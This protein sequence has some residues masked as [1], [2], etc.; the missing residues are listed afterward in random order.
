MKT[1]ETSSNETDSAR[2]K[3]LFLSAVAFDSTAERRAYLEEACEGDAAL[4]DRVNR[5]L[6][7]HEMDDALLDSVPRRLGEPDDA[8]FEGGEGLRGP[9]SGG[10]IG[11]YRLRRE[12]GEGGFGVVWEAEQVEP[13]RRRVALKLLRRDWIGFAAGS[14]AANESLARFRAEQQALARLRHEGIAQVYDAGV[15]SDGPHAGQPYY[16]MELVVGGLPLPEYCDRRRLDLRDRID[17]LTRAADAV[18]HAHTRGVLHRD[19]KPANVLVPSGDEHPA[20]GA[21]NA[22]WPKVIDFGIAKICDKTVESE[23]ATLLQTQPGMAL[24]TPLYAAPEQLAGGEA[25]TRSD[26]FSLGAMLYEL[27]AGM[28]ARGGSQHQAAPASELAPMSRRY[29]AMTEAD[30]ADLASRRCIARELLRRELR[31][32]LDW[33]VTKATAYEPE[34][35]YQ[36]AASLAADLRHWLDGE[37]VHA[38]PPGLMYQA[39]KVIGRHRRAFAAAA[40]AILSIGIGLAAGAVGLV[41]EAHAAKE[42]QRQADIARSVT[43][44]LT[45]DLLAAAKPSPNE[46]QGRDVTVREVL[47]LAAD[48]LDAQDKAAPSKSLPDPLVTSAIRKSLGDTYV[49]LGHFDLGVVQLQKA[50]SLR[51]TIGRVDDEGHALLL[52]SLGH[53]LDNAERP[54]EAVVTLRQSR[55]L[56]RRL[57][58]GHD[59][60][61]LLAAQ[62]LAAAM[63]RCGQYVEASQV[64]DE[65][66]AALNESGG[67]LDADSLVTTRLIRHQR[68][69]QLAMEGELDKVEELYRAQLADSRRVLGP[70]DLQ[71]LQTQIRLA[72]Y[73]LAGGAKPAEA[74]RLL[75]DAIPRLTNVAGEDHPNT[76]DARELLQIARTASTKGE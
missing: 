38:A 63:T 31:G 59:A 54:E 34:R 29:L 56:F 66:L 20:E 3:R 7:A 60:E 68:A 76:A 23:D 73:L 65:A 50:V 44:F 72:E 55:S 26:V 69:L 35:R 2:A 41:R 21:A 9:T 39:R 46:G 14:R 36:S 47:D 11:P 27:I 15:V 58:S 17:L 37:A 75:A 10:A 18:Q 16:A 61:R 45:D 19:L 1:V 6:D 71:T 4:L 67:G 57:R 49:A 28:P 53:A 62:R 13:I 70:D 42:S 24:G 43:A 40:V 33:I 8:T 30:Q 52:S 22:A 48:K 12:L 51:E 64:L 74:E 5:L 25:D 32:E